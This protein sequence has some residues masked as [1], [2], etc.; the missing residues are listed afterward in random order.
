[1]L[2]A[3]FTISVLF[4][5]LSFPLH[6]HGHA[7]VSA[8]Q[9]IAAANVGLFDLPQVALRV[10]IDHGFVFR[11]GNIRKRLVK[12]TDKGIKPAFDPSVLR[13]LKIKKINIRGVFGGDDAAF[14]AIASASMTAALKPILNYMTESGRV[15]EVHI[16]PDYDRTRLELE[17]TLR[18][19]FNLLVLI[20]IAISMIFSKKRNTKNQEDE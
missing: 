18:V 11:F 2:I 8:V 14:T 1:V 17:I 10:E 7:F 16:L 9:G 12:V 13:K 4:L 20:G 6:L 5:I 19:E 3:F 15:A